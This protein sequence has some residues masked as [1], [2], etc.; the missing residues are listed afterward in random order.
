[1]PALESLFDKVRGLRPATSVNF[2]LFLRAPFFI[3]SIGCFYLYQQNRFVFFFVFISSIESVEK[4]LM[5]FFLFSI[6]TSC[7][8]IFSLKILD[9]TILSQGI[10]F[11]Q[12]SA[13]DP[14]CR[15]SVPRPHKFSPDSFKE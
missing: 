1:M 13:L 15:P 12:P 4:S 9:K 14:I 3:T 2:A 6:F 11:S 7:S 10:C 8:Y 5:C